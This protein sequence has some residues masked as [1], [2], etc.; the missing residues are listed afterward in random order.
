MQRRYQAL[1]KYWEIIADHLSKAGCTWGMS[2]QI[3]SAGRVLFTADAHRSDGRR[4]VVWSD[5][6]LTAFFELER[7]GCQSKYQ[8]AI[9]DRP[10]KDSFGQHDIAGSNPASRSLR[11]FWTLVIHLLSFSGIFVLYPLVLSSA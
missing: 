11:Q 3:D 4:F 5:E 7:L 10:D 2:S 8:R 6:K 9:P 1:M